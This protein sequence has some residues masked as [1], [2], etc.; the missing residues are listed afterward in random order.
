MWDDLLEAALWILNT[1]VNDLAR[2]RVNP[3]VLCHV[4]Q[5][6]SLNLCHHGLTA[7]IGPS[8]EIAGRIES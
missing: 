8:G 2:G 3:P 1:G 7:G 4:A 6:T 5:M